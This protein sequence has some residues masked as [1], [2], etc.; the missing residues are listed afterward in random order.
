MDILIESSFSCHFRSA[1]Q[2]ILV[3]ILK[4][5]EP[6]EALTVL[7][8]L[9][10]KK[11]PLQNFTS[12]KSLNLQIQNIAITLMS[13][14]FAFAHGDDGGV[15]IKCQ[16]NDADQNGSAAD[17]ILKELQGDGLSDSE[18]RALCTVELLRELKKDSV[19]GDFFIYLAQE[20]TNLISNFSDDVDFGGTIFIF[21]EKCF[22]GLFINNYCS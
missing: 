21:N 15:I 18:L 14:N 11:S 12:T 13:D 6:H 9:A 10:F 5:T 16:S 17:G 20:L 7:Y 3:H 8:T 1:L 22:K 4:H 19:A 2:E